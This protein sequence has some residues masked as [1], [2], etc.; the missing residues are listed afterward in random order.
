MSPPRFRPGDV[1]VQRSAGRGLGVFAS[2]PHRI[3]ELIEFCPVI[4]VPAAQAETLNS[5]KMGSYSYQWGRHVA[6]AQGYGSLYNHS[7]EP[8]AFFVVDFE[9][10][11]IRIVARRRIDVGTEITIN[12]NGDPHDR[13][14]LWFDVA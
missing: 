13:H 11:G 10:R 7:Y 14:P 5:T 12:Y 1:Y 2:R 3:D 8:N 4:V 9:H 6:L